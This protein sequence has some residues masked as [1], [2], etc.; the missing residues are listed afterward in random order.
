M[1]PKCRLLAA[2]SPVFKKAGTFVSKMGAE[3]TPRP[4]AEKQKPHAS[5]AGRKICLPTEAERH[6]KA[7]IDRYLAHIYRFIPFLFQQLFQIFFRGGDR[8][9]S[10]ILYQVIQNIG[11]EEC[12]KG[13]A[14][15][16]V[17]DP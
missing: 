6:K 8:C 10:K 15:A 9:D 17:F 12:W 3:P 5:A 7:E 4:R 16:D 2:S 11:R 1:G 14:K 13:R